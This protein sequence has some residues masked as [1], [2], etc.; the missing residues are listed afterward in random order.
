MAYRHFPVRF[1]PEQFALIEAA[2]KQQGCHKTH[3]VRQAVDCFL[4]G[5]GQRSD[6]D[7]R[8]CRLSEYAQIALDTIIAKTYPELRDV[9]VAKTNERMVQY[10]GQ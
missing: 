3:I 10:H 2:A 6:R 9:I 5:Q 7:V 8:L 4:S 1:T